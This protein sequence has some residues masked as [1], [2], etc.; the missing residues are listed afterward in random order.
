MM[1]PMFIIQIIYTAII[2][3]VLSLNK[4]NGLVIEDGLKV[5][6]MILAMTIFFKLIIKVITSVYEK[7]L[8]NKFSR[9]I[10]SLR[11]VFKGINYVMLGLFIVSLFIAALSFIEMLISDVSTTTSCILL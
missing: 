5:A 3:I 4:H 1:S 9:N 2:I 8:Q 6:L 7:M 10:K 11:I